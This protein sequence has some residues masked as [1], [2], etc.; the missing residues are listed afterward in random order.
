M[1]RQLH[2]RGISLLAVLV[3]AVVGGGVAYATIPDG[4][5]V[6]HG[7]YKKSSGR[8][9]VIDTNAGASCGP[10]EE[11]ISW[12][13]AGPQ[14]QQGP[15]GPPGPSGAATTYNYRLG[16]MIPGTSVARAFCLPGEKVT[17]GGGFSTGP[18]ASSVGLTQDYPISD[19]SG[20][21]AFGTTAVGWQVASEGFG[22]VQA[23]VTCASSQ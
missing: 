2:P 4:K 6:I 18:S 11:A 1:K 8:L 20:V 21:I 5:G 16:L 14:G 3:V 7:C 22:T 12:N 23:F 15:T 19:A 17:G 9:R 10:A 13:Q